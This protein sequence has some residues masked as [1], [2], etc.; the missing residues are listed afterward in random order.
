MAT[1]PA[2]DLVVTGSPQVE[3]YKIM[4]D[5]A[6][7]FALSALL[8]DSIKGNSYEQAV[9]NCL[10]AT[11]MAH[12]MGEIPFVVM[13]N[14]HIVKGKAGFA[15]QYM[16][17]RANASGLFKGRLNWRIDKSDPKNLSVT[18]YATLAETEEVV[19]FTVD[20]AMAKA[21]GWTT[22]KKYE[23]MPEVMLRYRSA[24][25]LIRFYAPDVM[26]GYRTTDEIED[27]SFAEVGD[28][29][30][31]LNAQHLLDQSR[32][33]EAEDQVDEVT[34]EIVEGGAADAETPS[35]P[36]IVEAEIVEEVATEAPSDEASPAE[37]F[38]TEIRGGIRSAKNARYLKSVD[39]RWL[40][41]RVAYPEHVQAE[42]DGLVAAK[43][44][45][46]QDDAQGGE[47]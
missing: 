21:E 40:T 37:L 12:V 35:E 41:N 17:A 38:L 42:I 7:T 11:Q 3:A 34:G 46:L 9:A 25:F 28:A 31:P 32:P 29:P 47:G 45:E 4:K 20:M 23:T 14:I 6:R 15:A 18:C 16:I 24:T 8:P 13:Q 30:E 39:D 22:N 26:L 44:R 19:E 10:I 27:V 43:R 2:T 36:E 1:A 5:Q 33:Q